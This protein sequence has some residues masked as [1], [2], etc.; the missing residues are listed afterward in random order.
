VQLFKVESAFF[1]IKKLLKC[2]SGLTMSLYYT[3]VF[4]TGIWNNFH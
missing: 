3:R 1:R 2:E 4:T